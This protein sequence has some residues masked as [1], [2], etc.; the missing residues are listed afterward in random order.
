MTFNNSATYSKSQALSL[1]RSWKTQVDSRMALSSSCCKQTCLP[2]VA[3]DA[4]F[5]ELYMRSVDYKPP[6]KTVEIARI[7]STATFRCRRLI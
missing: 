5:C 4:Q 2:G 7:V 6:A 1:Q 3:V